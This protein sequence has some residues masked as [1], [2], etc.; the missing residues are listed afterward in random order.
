MAPVH[1]APLGAVGVQLVEHV[2][3]ALVEAQAVRIVDP[4]AVGGDVILRVPAVVALGGHLGHAGFGFFQFSSVVADGGE[5]RGFGS[6]VSHG[7]S[8]QALAASI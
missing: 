7:V 5:N 8:F 6:E 2:P 1:R 4:A 3:A